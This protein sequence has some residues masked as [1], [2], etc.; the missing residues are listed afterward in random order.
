MELATGRDIL[1]VGLNWLRMGT[2]CGCD[3][4][5]KSADDGEFLDQLISCGLVSEVACCVGVIGQ[6]GY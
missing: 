4:L 5:S 1:W 3:G 6:G 2:C